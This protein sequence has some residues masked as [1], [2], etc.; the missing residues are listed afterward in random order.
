MFGAQV[1]DCVAGCD[2]DALLGYLADK[3]EFDLYEGIETDP[4]EDDLAEA[5]TNEVAP[6]IIE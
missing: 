6:I 5:E 2:L 4:D 3:Q 1:A